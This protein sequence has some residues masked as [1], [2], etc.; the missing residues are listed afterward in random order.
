MAILTKPALRTGF[1]IPKETKSMMI[2]VFF[3]PSVVINIHC[4]AL[5]LNMEVNLEKGLPAGMFNSCIIIISG[6]RVAS[7]RFFDNGL[8]YIVTVI[9]NVGINMMP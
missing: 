3:F 6:A 5:P 8:G 4:P 7:M 1:V 9:R 2:V